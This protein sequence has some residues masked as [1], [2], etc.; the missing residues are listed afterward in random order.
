MI[1]ARP[2]LFVFFA[3]LSASTSADIHP[4]MKRYRPKALC[5]QI[6]ER[7]H[8][9]LCYQNNEK[10]SLWSLHFLSND[11]IRGRVNRTNNY[12][13]DHLLKNPVGDQDYK[14]S[15]FDRGHLVPAADMKLDYTSMSETF[16]MSNMTPQ[17][18]GFN[19]GI[20][21]SVER[22]V[23]SLVKN[24]GEAVVIT[25]PIIVAGLPRLK[26]GV[27]IPEDHYKIIFWPKISKMIAFL[28]PNQAASGQSAEDFFVTV[29][30][31]ETL[32]G[33]DFFSS[34]PDALEDQLESSLP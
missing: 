24:L 9:H 34:L 4:W 21:Q 19:R 8:Y 33:I 27:A 18:P 31:I 29:D 7:E 30:E 1:S 3:L 32:T 15:G 10:L 12:R 23:R 5:D 14:G 17:R 2:L 20:W 28:L 13:P 6:I 11:Y 16:F 22:K 26:S 25:A